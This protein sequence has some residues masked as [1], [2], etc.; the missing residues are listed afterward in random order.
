MNFSH[1]QVASDQQRGKLP[2]SDPIL[3][4][5]TIG[6]VGGGQLGRMLTIEAKKLGYR[7]GILDPV[8]NCPAAQVA[9]FAIVAEYSDAAAIRA[10]AEHSHVLTFEFENVMAEPLIEAAKLVPV[11]PAAAVLHV[12][13]NREREKLFLKRNGFPCAQF[14]VVNSPDSLR[15]AMERIST[16]CV[17]KTADFGYDGKGQLRLD[18]AC[19]TDAAWVN[20]GASRGVIESWVPYVAEFSVICAR[21]PDG[22]LRIF[23]P[24]ENLHR[25]HILDVS[26]V[27]ARLPEASLREAESLAREITEALDVTGLLAVELFLLHDG[28]VLVNELAP[29]PHNSGHYTFGGCITSQFEQHVRAICGLPLGVTSIHRPVVMVNLLGELWIEGATPDWSTLL[30]IPGLSL[31]LYGK[32]NPRRGR[33]MGHFCVSAPTQMESIR[34]ANRARELLRMPPIPESHL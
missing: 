12:A 28:S 23:P 22:S 6:I 1:K 17:L 24:A 19:D 10:L 15:A 30:T 4:G 20:F 14:E 31:H 2:M 33:K 32:E 26:I 5:S 21:G 7:V 8:E 25:D 34:L 27:P 3:P 29:R 18:P 13:Q 9:D 11:R 16:P